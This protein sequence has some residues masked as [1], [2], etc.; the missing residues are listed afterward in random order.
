M[1]SRY[2]R[3]PFSLAQCNYFTL[4]TLSSHNQFYNAFNSLITQSISHPLGFHNP[5][6]MRLLHLPSLRGVN[7]D[8]FD[9]YQECSSMQPF[10]V[11]G[12]VTSEEAVRMILDDDEQW[13][14]LRLAVRKSDART[15][16]RLSFCLD[17]LL[18]ERSAEITI[19]REMQQLEADSPSSF[20]S[21]R[22]VDSNS[23]RRSSSSSSPVLS[24]A[25]RCNA[26][27]LQ[28]VN[29]QSSDAL[30]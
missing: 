30:Y 25:R 5:N 17:D 20:S 29:L 7:T 11:T 14:K 3:S 18:Q 12:Q 27:K 6:K 15:N 13:N 4:S 22:S 24:R 16:M 9:T 23:F 26:R 21:L 19:R 2:A 28:S 1:R 10:S 8:M